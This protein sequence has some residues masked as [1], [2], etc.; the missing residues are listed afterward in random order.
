MMSE[1]SAQLTITQRKKLAFA[2]K[3]ILGN[4]HQ[5]SE[6]R[7]KRREKRLKDE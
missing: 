3:R 2:A 6:R 7:R 5:R 1:L 4:R